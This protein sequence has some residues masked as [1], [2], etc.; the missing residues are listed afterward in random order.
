M[1]LALTMLVALAVTGSAL[2]ASNNATLTIRHQMHGCHTWSFDGK[3]WN[4]S[5]SI[6]LSR[7]AVLTV[8]DNDVM[9]HKL[10]QVSGPKATVVHSAMNHPR[11]S[12]HVGFPAKGTYVFKTRA[13]EDYMKGIK[14]TG[15]DNMLKLVVK[16][17]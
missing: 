16:V 2:A 14:T 3:S 5:Q 11:A 7:G 12:A 6:V 9:S 13:G 15:E 10:I 17:A 8:V 4:A 1:K